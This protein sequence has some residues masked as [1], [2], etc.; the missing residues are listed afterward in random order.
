M[1]ISVRLCYIRNMNLKE[2]ENKAKEP[3]TEYGRYSY[4]D[5]LEWQMDEMVELIK[6]RV[7]RSAAAAP[8]RIHQ[9]NL[10]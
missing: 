5:Y 1:D 10:R 3:F 9:K 7:F 4:A 6:G 2:S 8:R